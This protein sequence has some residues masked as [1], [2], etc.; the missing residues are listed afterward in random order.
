MTSEIDVEEALA[1]YYSLRFSVLLIT[2]ITLVLTISAL[3]V[4]LIIGERSTQ[5]MRRARDELENRVKE[6]TNEVAEKEQL[7]RL[8]IDNIP[9]GFVLYDSDDRLLLCN[10]QYRQ[11]YLYSNDLIIPGA[12]FEDIIREGAKRGEYAQAIGREEE[13]VAE[14]MARRGQSTAAEI[15]LSGDRW[16]RVYDKK[17][18][19]GMN[20]GVRIDI[21][22]LKNS[23][24]IANKANQAKS[25]FLS[26]MS[27]ELRT[28]MNA[29]LGFGQMLDF[30]H[31]Q[32]MTKAQKSCVDHIMKGGQH[33]LDLINDILDLARIDSGKVEL[34]IE[35][36]ST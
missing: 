26:S 20:L 7:L 16:I 32:P 12:R 31:K 2:G 19:N 13:W 35:N 22:E 18:P 36:I 6:R 1:G 14:R 33:Q 11:I 8:A 4:T 15:E 34:S 21:S 25:D 23:K 29:I 17:L 27:H 5:V 28:P 3:L 9:D 30:N 10:K 24:K